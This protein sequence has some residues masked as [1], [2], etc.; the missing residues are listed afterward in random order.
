MLRKSYN[1]KKLVNFSS[2]I[3]DTA[4]RFSSIY[5]GGILLD[6]TAIWSGVF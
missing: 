3:Q 2:I 5:S 4:A 1:D 6:I